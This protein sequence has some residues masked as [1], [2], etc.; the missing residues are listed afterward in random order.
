MSERKRRQREPSGLCR[1]RHHDLCTLNSVKML[2]AEIRSHVVQLESAIAREHD[3]LG[4]RD[5]LNLDRLL[6]EL[7]LLRGQMAT[8]AARNGSP[9]DERHSALFRSARR[10]LEQ[11]VGDHTSLEDLKHDRKQRHGLVLSRK[12]AGRC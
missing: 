8:H 12:E 5:V 1:W 2:G 10:Q 7:W 4:D 9:V 3:Q 6:Q 11:S